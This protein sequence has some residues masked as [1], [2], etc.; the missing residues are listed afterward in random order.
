MDHRAHNRISK[1][2]DFQ[3]KELVFHKEMEFVLVQH[4]LSIAKE[5]LLDRSQFIN[6]LT[7]YIPRLVTR[8]DNHNLNRA[9]SEDE[10][11][12]VINEIQNGKAL[13]PDGFNADI[14]K[15]CWKTVKQD[16]LE[17]V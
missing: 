9:V 12:E 1:L 15:A 2:R 14:F 17:V 6:K 3:G 16:I 5:P 7:R 10:V 8:E 13:G 4:F 11:N